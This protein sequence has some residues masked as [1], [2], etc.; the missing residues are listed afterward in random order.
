[1]TNAQITKKFLDAT[2]APVREQI[3]GNIAANYGISKESALLEIL[4]D[5]AEHLLDYVT[6]PVRTSTSLL[7]KRHGLA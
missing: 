5:D 3:L 6:G 4:D 7:M 2:D 1:M